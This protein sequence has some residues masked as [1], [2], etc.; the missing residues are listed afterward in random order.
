MNRL[1]ATSCANW[2]PPTCLGRRNAASSRRAWTSL[3]PT[4][5][6]RLTA[7][8]PGVDPN[9]VE[10]SLVADVLILRAEHKEDSEKKDGKKQYRLVEWSHGSSLRRIPLPFEADEDKIEA[11]FEQGLLKIGIPR[12]AQIEQDVENIAIRATSGGGANI[13]SAGGSTSARAWTGVCRRAWEPRRERSH[14]LLVR[15][16]PLPC[17]CSIDSGPL[18]VPAISVRCVVFR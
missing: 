9:N 1:L 16:G 11:S 8:I 15:A 17:A 5:V 4:R 13:G 7:E 12:S 14:G 18:P 3:R 2:K 10:L 6:W